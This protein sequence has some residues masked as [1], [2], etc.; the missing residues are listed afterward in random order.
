M[1]ERVPQRIYRCPECGYIT[2]YRWV[3]ARHLYN[4]HRYYKKDAAQAA[5][6]NEYLLH[7]QYYRQ[8]DLLKRYEEQD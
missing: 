3:L 4:V 1:P 2:E 8:R 5:I 7:P 6:E